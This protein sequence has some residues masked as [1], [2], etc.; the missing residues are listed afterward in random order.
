MTTLGGPDI[1]QAFRSQLSRRQSST[2]LEDSRCPTLTP[3]YPR[4]ACPR[5]AGLGQACPTVAGQLPE[6]GQAFEV[7][8]TG[9]HTPPAVADG[10]NHRPVH[11]GVSRQWVACPWR[12]W[13]IRQHFMGSAMKALA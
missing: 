10:A 9:P 13:I 1:Q 5:C 7:V 3:S 11:V 6:P 8:G 2:T 4:G 12:S